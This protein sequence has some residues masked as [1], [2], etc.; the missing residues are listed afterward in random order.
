MEATLLIAVIR[1][2]SKKISLLQQLCTVWQK[3]YGYKDVKPPEEN[4]VFL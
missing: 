2:H 3:Y 1:F 4:G